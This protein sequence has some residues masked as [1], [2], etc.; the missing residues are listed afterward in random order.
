MDR[1][2]PSTE[3]GRDV[4]PAEVRVWDPLVRAFHWSLVA[5]FAAAWISGEE[6]EQLHVLLGYAVASLVAFRLAWGIVGPKHARFSDFVYRPSRVM[7]YLRDTMALRARRHLRHNPAGGAM[8]VALLAML[9]AV[10]ATG[11]MMT[12]DA[13]WGLE[14]V[15]EAHEAAVNV[16][17]VLVAVHILGVALASWEHR[18]NLVKSMI[19][20]RKRA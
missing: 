19:T 10:C 15:E 20:G 14:W 4:R 17:L 13:F 8:V 5:A 12:T 6:W 7:S 16:A 9:A 2:L 3:A 11:F 1:T 18:E